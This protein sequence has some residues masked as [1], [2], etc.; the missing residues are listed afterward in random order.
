MCWTKSR[1]TWDLEKNQELKRGF[2]YQCT[3]C[4]TKRNDYPGLNRKLD[5]LTKQVS[6]LTSKPD[7]SHVDQLIGEFEE[8]VRRK[9]NLIVFGVAESSGGS[10]DERKGHDKDTI[11]E[12]IK[13][14]V[15][16]QE[17]NNV[18]VVNSFKL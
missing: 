4:F 7:L 6:E 2:F 15:A 13:V 3:V 1:W 10:S 5:E 8:R 12:I 18:N 9:N 17:Q 11:T 14:T 16:D